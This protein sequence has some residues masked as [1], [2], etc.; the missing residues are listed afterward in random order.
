MNSSEQ[1]IAAAAPSDV[2]LHYNFV[3]GPAI[4]GDLMT[5]SK[6]YLS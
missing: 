3:S 4:L 6:V 5:Y 2:G 1:R